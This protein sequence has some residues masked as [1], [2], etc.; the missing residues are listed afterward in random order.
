[1]SNHLKSPPSARI[2]FR[3]LD[4]KH[5]AYAYK[6]EIMIDYDNDIIY[7]KD[8]D[9]NIR[10]ITESMVSSTIKEIITN[11]DKFDL[12]HNIHITYNGTTY[13][14]DELMV[15]INNITDSIAEILGR[16]ETDL[17][18]EN[19]NIVKDENGEN[20]KQVIFKTVETIFSKIED[21]KEKDNEII[22]E[23]EN[24]K[25]DISLKTNTYKVD[26]NIPISGWSTITANKDYY[27]IINIPNIKES[28]V[29]FVYLVKS[30][31]YSAAMMETSQFC[32]IYRV[33]SNTGS[34]TIY[35]KKI[36]TIPLNISMLI[37]RNIT[38]GVSK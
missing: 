12:A 9:G 16:E 32:N 14:L 36:P 33:T 37:P 25:E 17:K 24:I 38:N 26:I 2:P 23:L 10:N 8:E 30:S 19:G 27:T 21:L 7:Y 35:S 15:I 6:K 11:P 20:V 4:Y 22:K 31:N 28:D 29:A 18:D 1:M 34:I 3:P 13:P 5:M